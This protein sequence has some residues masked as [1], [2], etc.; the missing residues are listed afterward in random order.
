MD[1]F[2]GILIAAIS[3]LANNLL[4]NNVI[5]VLQCASPGRGLSSPR[6]GEILG[7][8]PPAPAGLLG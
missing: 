4:L 8:P 2:V 3:R 1:F 5:R 6:A 7:F